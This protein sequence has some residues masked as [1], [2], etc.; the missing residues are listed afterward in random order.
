MVRIAHISDSHLGA[1]MF[2]LTERKEDMRACFQRAI[3]RVIK[4]HPDILVHTGDLFDSPEPAPEDLHLT[5]RMF[6]Q[7]KDAG[8]RAFVVQGN[9]DLAGRH[10]EVSPIV[11]LERAGLAK[12]TIK[13][14]DRGFKIKVDGEQVYIHLVSWG[15]EIP[16]KKILGR[17]EPRGDVKLLFGHSFDLP[18]SK[19]PSGFDYIGEG[20]AHNYRLDKKNG[21]G[22]PGSTAIVNWDKELGEGRKR[23]I[24]IVDVTPTGNKY[25]TEPL[26]DVREFKLDSKADITG[27]TKQE[28]NQYLKKVVENIQLQSSGGIV[29]IKVKGSIDPETNAAIKREDILKYGEQKHNSLLVYLDA[30]W[31]VKGARPIRLSKPLD[32]ELTVKEYIE[33]SNIG[34]LKVLL[35]TLRKFQK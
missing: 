16:T 11:S 35:D 34:D 6:K 22:R 8:I 4:Y 12:T 15:Y 32:V 2:Q 21:I 14:Q 1:A 31:E 5:L 24:I 33:Q 7:V 25:I 26:N 29:I 3:E 19:L 28:V 18:W 9:H 30:E 10:W 23:K 20:H 13:K 27:K 17:L